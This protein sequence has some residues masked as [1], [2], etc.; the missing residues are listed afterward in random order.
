MRDR[1]TENAVQRA[2]RLEQCAWVNRRAL[3]PSE[4]RLWSALSAR[5][6]GVQFRRQVPLA[7]RFVVDFAAPS[8]RL[9]VEVDGSYHAQRRAADR[10]RDAVLAELGWRVLRLEAELVIADLQTAVELVRQAAAG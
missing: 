6:L 10:R 4:A 5:K 9:V 1:K 8:L 3:T 2:L 7:G